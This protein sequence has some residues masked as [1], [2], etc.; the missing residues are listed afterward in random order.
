VSAAPP[1]TGI[2]RMNLAGMATPDLLRLAEKL[3]PDSG[4][5][6]AVMMEL[7]SREDGTL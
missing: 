7:A 1:V 2:M 6:A 5:F 3:P 4:L